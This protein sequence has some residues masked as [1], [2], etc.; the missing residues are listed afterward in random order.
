MRK[1][2]GELLDAQVAAAETLL[3]AAQA[4]LAAQQAQRERVLE[5]IAAGDREAAVAARNA[6]WDGVY[7][8]HKQLYAFDEIWNE[9]SPRLAQE[10]S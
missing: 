2:I 5:A 4:H 7:A 10:A 8:V 6:M 9:T 1:P 3:Q